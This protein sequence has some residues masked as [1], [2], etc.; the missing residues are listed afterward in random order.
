MSQQPLDANEFALWIA[1]IRV[2]QLLPDRLDAALREH[3]AT[4]PRYEVLSVLDRF[5]DGLRFSD[6][7]RYALVSK[8]RLSVH[9][10][11]LCEIG[12]LARRPDPADGRASILTITPAGSAALSAWRPCHIALAREL[13]VDNIDPADR[14]VVLDA[15]RR[16]GSSL[17]DVI[18]P[19]DVTALHLDSGNP[20]PRE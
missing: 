19:V 8:S 17:G 1:L 4:L 13:V 14:A 12:Y 15:L 18:D 9:V 20:R 2:S 7:G 3:G 6:V 10:S 11:E 5:P 16:I